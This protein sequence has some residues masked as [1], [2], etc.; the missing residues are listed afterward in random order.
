MRLK[1]YVDGHSKSVEALVE[2]EN[3][4]NEA[5]AECIH[6]LSTGGKIVIAGN[7]G[8]AS[9][10]AHFAGELVGRLDKERKSLAAIALCA[11]SATLTCIANDFGYENVFS[12]QIG[13]IAQPGDIFF[14]ISTSG[15][16]QNIVNALRVSSQIGVKSVFLTSLK[17]RGTE[18]ISDHVIRVPAKKTNY[19]QE[20]HIMIIHYICFEIEK[21]LGL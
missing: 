6:T 16:S 1:D 8:S 5:V 20:L 15:R 14:G 13:S 12:R 3:V 19:I 4:I 21:K 11:D 7:G 9:D 18:K 17:Y 10:A 2:L